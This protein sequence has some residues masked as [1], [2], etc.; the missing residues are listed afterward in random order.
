MYYVVYTGVYKMPVICFRVDKETLRLLREIA[1]KQGIT[2]SDLM[3][4]IL[5]KYLDKPI[6]VKGDLEKRVQ[7]LEKRVEKLEKMIKKIGGLNYYT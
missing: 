5:S 7:E 1:E 2:V 6:N 4:A 3:R